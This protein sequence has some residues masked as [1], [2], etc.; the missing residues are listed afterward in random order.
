MI[1]YIYNNL[2]FNIYNFSFKERVDC[3]YNLINKLF[4]TKNY[5][6]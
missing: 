1:T 6:L 4:N 3:C 5:F 2:F